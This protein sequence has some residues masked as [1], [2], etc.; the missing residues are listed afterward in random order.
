MHILHSPIRSHGNL[1]K[2]LKWQ[3]QSVAKV[4]NMSYYTYNGTNRSD[5]IDT[6][7]IADSLDYYTDGIILNGLGGDDDLSAIITGEERIDEINGGAGDDF[8]YASSIGTDF[9]V[10]ILTGDE[11]SD[12]A[13]LPFAINN[14]DIKEN[15]GV[16]FRGFSKSGSSID[17][18]VDVS[19]ETIIDSTGA[20]YLVEDLYNGRKRSVS[21]DEW[22]AR[23]FEGNQDWYFR[24]LDTY[25]WYHSSKSDPVT[26]GSSD[27][28]DVFTVPLGKKGKW[29]SQSKTKSSDTVWDSKGKG[30]RQKF[31]VDNDFVTIRD[32]NIE[33]DYLKLDGFKIGKTKIIEYGSYSDQSGQYEY[34]DLIMMVGSNIVA[35]FPGLS[36][37]EASQGFNLA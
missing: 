35:Y 22:Y 13:Y 3:D 10:A 21:S 33:S 16:E 4:A 31:L 25:T 36:F 30:K 17:I 9:A 27:V 5:E 34:T 2:H 14:Y 20:Y 26:G 12:T 19:T 1:R 29:Y 23:S 15:L 6:Q 8:M 7:D 37:T 28:S 32:F 11:G 18:L 24:G